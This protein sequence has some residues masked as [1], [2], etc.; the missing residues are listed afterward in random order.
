MKSTAN[1]IKAFLITFRYFQKVQI[2]LKKASKKFQNQNRLIIFK[3]TCTKEYLYFLCT[4]K[5]EEMLSKIKNFPNFDH[6]HLYSHYEF[7]HIFS[8]TQKL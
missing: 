6:A 2:L 5:D 4:L 8:S 7:F 1:K 3:L